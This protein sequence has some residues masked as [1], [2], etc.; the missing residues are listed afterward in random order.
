[1]LDMRATL[2]SSLPGG[3]P[4]RPGSGAGCPAGGGRASRRYVSQPPADVAHT[5]T[6]GLDGPGTG[7]YDA[8]RGSVVRGVLRTCGGRDPT[9]ARL[10][11]GPITLL[12]NSEARR[13]QSARDCLVAIAALALL[14]C[15]G[16]C[17]PTGSRDVS[18][19]NVGRFDAASGG[20][21]GTGG[22]SGGESGAGG[23]GGSAAP[24]STA[25]TG[26]IADASSEGGTRRCARRHRARCAARGRG[27]VR[28]GRALRQ[29]RS[30]PVRSVCRRCL[31]CQ[32]LHHGVP[33]L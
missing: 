1:M 12:R 9:G 6:A 2:P 18:S 21:G 7:G 23:S 30:M 20:R 19:V 25:G 32:C 16:A 17:G 4:G 33:C 8:P 3:P 26:G 13:R 29:R 14:G 11:K 24:G 15:L 10:M 27:A 31:L 28:G 22:G 5:E